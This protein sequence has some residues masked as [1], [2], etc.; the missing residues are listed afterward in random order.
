VTTERQPAQE[1]DTATIDVWSIALDM[2]S[3]ATVE[4][5]LSARDRRRAALRS[6][7]ERR[8]FRARHAALRLIAAQHLGLPE[9]RIELE[10]P[11]GERPKC[12]GVE[13]SLSHAGGFALIAVAPAGKC[14][15]IDLETDAALPLDEVDEVA[16]FVLAPPE[17]AAVRRLQQEDRR[18]AV[19]GAWCRKEAYLKLRGRGLGDTALA[20]IVVS[21]EVV[22]RAG[23]DNVGGVHL[24]DVQAPA[25]HVAAVAYEGDLARVAVHPRTPISDE[26]LLDVAC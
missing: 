23:A 6:G 17:L 3:D 24:A 15:G 8:R 12:A 14:V 22:I 19:L 1:A 21:P 20:D 26:E 2:M 7:A 10:A 16:D 9:A 11:Y 4:R 13:L 5:A 25:G 18:R